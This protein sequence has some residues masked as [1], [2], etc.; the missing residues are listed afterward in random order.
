MCVFS[1]NDPA[2]RGSG[3]NGIKIIALIWVYLL[4]PHMTSLNA[5]KKYFVDNID[6]TKRK[7]IRKKIACETKQFP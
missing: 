4:N 7:K 2:G 1:W 6:I 3:Y 5:Y